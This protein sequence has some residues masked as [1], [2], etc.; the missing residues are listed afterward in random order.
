MATETYFKNFNTIQYANNAVVDI[1]ERVVTLNNVKKNPYV[2]YPL[3]ITEGSRPDQITDANYND[4]YASWVLYLSNDIVDPYYEWYLTQEQFNKFIVSKYGSPETAMKKIAFWRNDWVGKP[5]ISV[6]EYNAE[7]AAN[8]ARI[9]YWTANYN[10]IGKIVS[11]SRA[12]TDWI[13]NTNKV[14]QYSIDTSDLTPIKTVTL[15]DGTIQQEYFIKNEIVSINDGEGQVLQSNSS[16][17]I[18]NNITNL[19][20]TFS[21]YISNVPNTVTNKEYANL[22]ANQKKLFHPV[23]LVD[24]PNNPNIGVIIG[25]ESGSAVSFNSSI[26][27]ALSISDNEIDYWTTVSY[28]N[29]ENE[30]NQG[31]K[32][33]RVLQPQY[34]PKYIK[35]VKELLKG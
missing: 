26:I 21:G 20:L 28:Y 22:G 11:Y 18:V 10:Y 6:S 4:P 15:P 27:N 34:V 7:I 12:K 23:V 1:T 29:V 9:K 17:L 25:S 13:T 19:S 8:S 32:S 16:V 35:N 3:D 14:I 33:I 30:K 31:N 24:G 5:D 2:Y